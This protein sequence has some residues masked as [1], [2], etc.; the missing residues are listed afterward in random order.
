VSTIRGLGRHTPYD[1]TC[2]SGDRVSAVNGLSGTY[3]FELLWTP[4]EPPPAGVTLPP[5]Y[6]PNG[7]SL[8]TAAQ[9]QLGLKLDATTGP[10]DVLVIDGAERPSED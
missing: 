2:V 3:D 8:G 1:Q 10:V 9:E 4:D 6:D 5:W 7:P